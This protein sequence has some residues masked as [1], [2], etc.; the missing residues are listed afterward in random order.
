[1]NSDIN[2]NGEVIKIGTISINAK[3]FRKNKITVITPTIIIH[4]NVLMP[5]FLL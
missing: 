5:P 1:M 3:M 4:V 2:N